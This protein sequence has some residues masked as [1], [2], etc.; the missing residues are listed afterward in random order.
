MAKEEVK[1]E[2]YN[3]HSLFVKSPYFLEEDKMN[4]ASSCLML[5]E[6]KKM[7]PSSW[8]LGKRFTF[9]IGSDA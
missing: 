4:L 1:A 2:V 6:T 9:G 8:K 5:C 3:Y 7:S